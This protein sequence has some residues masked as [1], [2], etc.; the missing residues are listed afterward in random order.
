MVSFLLIGAITF[1]AILFTTTTAV[2][3]RP[4][5]IVQNIQVTFRGQTLTIREGVT[6]VKELTER[7]EQISGKNIGGE[8]SSSQ[9]PSSEE[10]AAASL[11]NNN[12]KKKNNNDNDNNKKG[13][14]VWKGEILKPDTNLSKAGIKNGDHVMILPT[15]K[16][17]KATDILAFYLF[18]L[19]SNEKAIEQAI[20]KIKEEQPE[21]F[22]T[23][24]ETW[25]EMFDST[26]DNIH[27]LKKQDVTDALRTNFDLAY[28]RMRSWWEHPLLRQGLHDP[29][30]IEN[31]RK[32]VAQNLSTKVLKKYSIPSPVQN[33]IKSPQL[34]KKEFTKFVVKAIR[35]GDTILEGILDL[36]LDVLKGRGSSSSSSSPTQQQ[37]Q[38][39]G[40]TTTAWA[41][42]EATAHTTLAD[43]YT[44]EMED[45]SLANNLLDELS[46]SE[47]D[48]EE[49]GDII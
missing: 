24:Q 48:F 37:R 47:D 14:I 8:K 11:N 19:S 2:H 25:K 46:E 1:V 38:N 31:Y 23:I 26:R 27:H 10:A 15:G 28:H 49:D 22:E 12:Y 33:A 5:P 36:L 30:R 6:T 43:T 34:W 16:E 32:V 45:P 44:D 39:R 3:G 20:A 21:T 29:I 35:F 41:S 17:S 18:L 9:L 42:A 4:S 7:F 40:T 13:M